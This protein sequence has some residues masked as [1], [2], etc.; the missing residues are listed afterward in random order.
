[1]EG[2]QE[3][4]CSGRSHLGQILSRVAPDSIQGQDHAYYM[5]SQMFVLGAQ[6]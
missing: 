5:A 1:M 3:A 4:S 2:Q 6:K